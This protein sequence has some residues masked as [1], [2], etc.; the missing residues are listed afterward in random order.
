MFKNLTKKI[1][2][3]F[4]KIKY[5]GILTEKN[6]ENTVTDIKNALLD[7]D[8]SIQVINELCTSIKKKI[9]GKKINKNLTPGEKFIE[10]VFK[11]LIKIMGKNCKKL[12]FSSKNPTI[13]LII[14]LQGSGKTTSTAKIAYKLSKKNKKVLV[15]SIDIY[16]PAAITQ[17]EILIKKTKAFFLIPNINEKPI[18]I[19]KKSIKYAKEKLYDTIIIDSAGRMHIDKPKIKEIKEI[20]N[21]IKPNEI[22]LVIDAMIGQDSI[23]VIQKF[24]KYF[25]ISGIIISKLDSDTR[26]GVALS[27]KYLTKKSIKYIGIGEKIYD[28][29]AFHPER[30]A[31]RIL[32]MGDILSLIDKINNEVSKKDK[33]LLENTLSKKK[34]FNLNDFLVQIKQIKKIKNAT[35]LIQELPLDI[36]PKNINI[37]NF[38]KKVL[39]KMEAIIYSMTKQERKNPE[40]IKNS[41]KK[42]I[43]LGS[44]VN[45][46]DINICLKQF[47]QTKKMMKTFKKNNFNNL[48]DKI[49]NY[50]IK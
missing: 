44:G 26:G 7:A 2:N 49:K 45:I 25:N 21:K 10:I 34:L 6:I 39:I 32:G 30:I 15:T 11:E 16:R 1:K 27:V 35:N 33:K 5:Q 46:Q 42:R 24:N 37:H 36:L 8:V 20:Q 43:A 12:H 48:L 22:L 47:N 4:N 18:E 9:L 41:R 13:I 50:F 14:G 17:L 28:L 38:N 31:R 3:I 23:N 29:Q 19:A 40:I